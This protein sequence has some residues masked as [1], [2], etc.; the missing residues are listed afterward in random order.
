MTEVHRL[1]D[2]AD[3][4]ARMTGAQVEHVENPRKEALDNDLVVENRNLLDLGLDP[5]TLE[6]ELLTEVMD[7][8]LRYRDRC[9]V[10]KI[11]CRSLWVQPK[12]TAPAP[13]VG[14]G[15]FKSVPTPV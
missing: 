6:Q 14:T 1:R 9:D 11:P 5:I 12:A 2:L 3:I 15:R 8:A 10:E 13:P 4:V 7:V